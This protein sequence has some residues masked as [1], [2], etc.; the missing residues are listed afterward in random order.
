MAAPEAEDHLSKSTEFRTTSPW[1]Y[2]REMEGIKGT[3]TE[4]YLGGVVGEVIH[5]VHTGDSF[6][7]RGGSGD[8]WSWPDVIRVGEVQ[9]QK[10]KRL[11][12]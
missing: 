3:S 12:E 10:L 5:L 2:E 4:K 1:L 6:A 9:S 8:G 11:H 7:T